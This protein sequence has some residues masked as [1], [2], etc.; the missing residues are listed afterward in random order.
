MEF[1]LNN[2]NNLYNLIGFIVIPYHVPLIKTL[3]IFLD[4]IFPP[5]TSFNLETNFVNSKAS[6]TSFSG[7]PAEI[8]VKYAKFFNNPID[9]PSGVS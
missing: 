9:P 7:V 3:H 6:I 4:I 5:N 2:L 8:L 1:N